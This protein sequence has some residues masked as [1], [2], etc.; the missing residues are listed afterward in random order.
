[1]TGTG[2]EILRDWKLKLEKLG[3]E[4]THILKTAT[5]FEHQKNV[6]LKITEISLILNLI[7]D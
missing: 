7:K 1:M 2:M 3:L 4:E 5:V 6:T